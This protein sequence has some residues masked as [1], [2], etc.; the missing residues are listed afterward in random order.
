MIG[1]TRAA[2]DEFVDAAVLQRH[3]AGGAGEVGLAQ[4]HGGLIVIVA[5]VAEVEPE[6]LSLVDAA[7][8]EEPDGQ[9]IQREL[10]AECRKDGLDG[11]STVTL[12]LATF[13]SETGE[14]QEETEEPQFITPFTIERNPF[15]SVFKPVEKG[16]VI[17]LPSFSL[18]T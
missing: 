9:R 1:A 3:Q 13:L 8:Y 14:G 2:L 4:P 17:T 5:F 16:Q 7:R 11:V 15:V 6:Q 10:D 18:I 12:N